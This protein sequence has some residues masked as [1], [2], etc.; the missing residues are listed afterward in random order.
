MSLLASARIFKQSSNCK[1]ADAA[2]VPWP[3]NSGAGTGLSWRLKRVPRLHKPR[4]LALTPV[5]DADTAKLGLEK[6]VWECLLLVKLHLPAT[7]FQRVALCLQ[8]LLAWHVSGCQCSEICL[9]Q[10]QGIPTDV[11]SSPFTC[12]GKVHPLPGHAI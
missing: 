11:T 4:L 10:H 1:H 9:L 6:A 5:L 3:P 2:P 8:V 12:I 7:R